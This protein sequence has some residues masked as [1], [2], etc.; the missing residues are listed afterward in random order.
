VFDQKGS[1][2]FCEVLDR[3]VL[4]GMLC[5]TLL[6][7]FAKAFINHSVVAQPSDLPIVLP[8]PSEAKAIAAI[9]DAIISEQKKK[10]SFDYRS[11][12]AELDEVI[13]GIYSLT[14]AERD[15]LSTW[16]QRH[17]PKLTGV[18]TDEG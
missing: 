14:Q 16:Y 11:K 9:V 4:L 17:Y 12:L 8:E 3:R 7:Y 18:G 1:N 13:A 5:S 15:E 10:L 2:I 6:R